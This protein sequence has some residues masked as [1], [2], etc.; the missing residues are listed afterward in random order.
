M[1]MPDW[2]LETKDRRVTQM[3][4]HHQYHLIETIRS[5]KVNILR[6]LSEYHAQTFEQSGKAV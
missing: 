3:A 2:E 6:K 4:C 1:Q 5:F